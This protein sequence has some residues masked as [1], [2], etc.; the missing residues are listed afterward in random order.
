M[1]GIIFLTMVWLI[2]AA[3]IYLGMD[4]SGTAYPL[5]GLI[6]PALVSLGVMGKGR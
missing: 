1:S 3:L 5:F 4:I 2:S 6:I